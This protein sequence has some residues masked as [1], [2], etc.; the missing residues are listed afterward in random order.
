MSEFVLIKFL[1]HSP[2]PGT[3]KACDGCVL[4][5]LIQ[6]PWDVVWPLGEE[7][8]S[9]T[10]RE[11]PQPCGLGLRAAVLPPWDCSNE[12]GTG[13]GAQPMTRTPAPSRDL[14]G[15]EPARLR[16][17]LGALA[18]NPTATLQSPFVSPLVVAPWEAP[19]S[20]ASLSHVAPLGFVDQALGLTAWGTEHLQMQLLVIVPQLQPQRLRA[21]PTAW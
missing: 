15:G 10:Q 9:T 4:C 8:L 6:W 1:A 5:V 21:P 2:G 18:H 20:L 12:A 19:S 17:P 16:Y 13:V 3:E 14:E 7:F 11:G